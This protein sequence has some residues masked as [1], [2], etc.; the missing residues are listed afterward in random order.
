MT[1]RFFHQTGKSA[2][3]QRKTLGRKEE[4]A[5]S[6]RRCFPALLSMRLNS[7]S[8][9]IETPFERISALSNLE[10]RSEDLDSYRIMHK[11]GRHDS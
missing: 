10:G 6:I 1:L 4:V 7:D 11:K 3:L 9:A 5:L 8:L 2:R